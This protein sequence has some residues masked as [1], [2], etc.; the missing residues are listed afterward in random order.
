[1]RYTFEKVSSVLSDKFSRLGN[2]E[3]K[4]MPGSIS[5]QI[6]SEKKKIQRNENGRECIQ[7]IDSAR[8]ELR[9]GGEKT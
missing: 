8:N 1:M 6:E 5:L 9:R 7:G 3:S 4:K 2:E